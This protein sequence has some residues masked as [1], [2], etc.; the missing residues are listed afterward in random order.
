MGWESLRSTYLLEL[1]A[2]GF[3]PEVTSE[4]S[5]RFKYESRYFYVTDACDETYFSV[6]Y[7]SFWEVRGAKDLVGASSAVNEV[8]AD[9][10]LAKVWIDMK[11]NSVWAE[12]GFL[13]A[14]SRRIRPFVERALLCIA[15]AVDDFLE[16]VDEIRE[17][18][19]DE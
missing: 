3:K 14:D 15:E 16:T 19:E 18:I 10:K 6:A 7:P 2:A 5:I 12:V 4:G 1:S 11:A 8:N 9:T 17:V 13:V